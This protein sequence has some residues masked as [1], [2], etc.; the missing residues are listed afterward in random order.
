MSNQSWKSAIAQVVDESYDGTGGIYLDEGT[1]TLTELRSLTGA[2]ASRVLPGAG[3][4]V[5]NQVKHL[6]TAGAMHRS[7]FAGNGF[8]DLDWGADWADQSLSDD[9]WQALVD[10]YAAT[11]AVLKDA[12][13]NPAMDENE[14]FVAAA[15]ML[16]GHLAYHTGQIR[17]AAAYAKQEGE[18]V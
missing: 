14:E 4:S 3:N 18:Q 17:H 5:A 16:S 1:D 15:V 7:Q 6:L 2:Q 8:P 10:D 9:E 13:Q 11:R 12:L